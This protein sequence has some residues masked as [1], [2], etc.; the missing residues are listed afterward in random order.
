M[1]IRSAIPARTRLG[2]ARGDQSEEGGV[3]VSSSNRVIWVALLA[4]VAAVLIAVLYRLREKQEQAEAAVESID[5]ELDALDPATRAAVV[6]KLTSEE[7][8]KVR[9]QRA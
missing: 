7:V 2:P 5:A 8:E 9:G 6:A 3:G 4:A 1:A